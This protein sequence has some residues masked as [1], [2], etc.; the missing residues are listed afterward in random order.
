MAQAVMCCGGCTAAT[1]SELGVVDMPSQPLVH[2]VHFCEDN[3]M[4]M[5]V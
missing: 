2:F 4:S 5:L 3:V 1:F